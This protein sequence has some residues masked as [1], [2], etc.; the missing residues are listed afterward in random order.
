MEQTK[1]RIEQTKAFQNLETFAK[2]I[3]LKRKNVQIIHDA[4][5]VYQNTGYVN[6]SIGDKSLKILKELIEK[7]GTHEK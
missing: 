6:P 2:E 1:K 4:F 7:Y 5:V 3:Y